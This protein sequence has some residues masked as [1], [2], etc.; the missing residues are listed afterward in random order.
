MANKMMS[1]AETIWWV[2]AGTVGFDRDAI[3][4]SL[5][6]ESLN[7]SCAIV[8][9]YTLNPTDSDTDDTTSICN[10]SNSAEPTFY[11]YEANLTFFREE[12]GTNADNTSAY[13]RAYEFFKH[14]DADGYLVRRV[15][16]KFD[17]PAAAGDEVDVFYVQS[18]YPQ[19]VVSD[20]GGPIQM[21]VPFLPQ[22]FMDINATLVA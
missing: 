2:P 14:V 12:T 16:K 5:L 19:D 11:N 8:S 13:S 18:D 4:A 15:G 21:T 3:K 22:G 10:G 20:S 1:P 17:A 7:I 6:T 9:G